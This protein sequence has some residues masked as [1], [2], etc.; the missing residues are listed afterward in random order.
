MK[1]L[2]QIKLCTEVLHHSELSAWLSDL[3]T[4]KDVRSENVLNLMAKLSKLILPSE[5]FARTCPKDENY[6]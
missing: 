5:I 1:T 2:T 4:L 3:G 6:T